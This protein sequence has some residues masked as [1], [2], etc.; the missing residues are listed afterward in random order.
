MIMR[1]RSDIVALVTD[2][3]MPGADGITLIR[4]AR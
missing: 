2:L 1:E 3:S 4:Q